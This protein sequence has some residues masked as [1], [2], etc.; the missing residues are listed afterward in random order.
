MGPGTGSSQIQ[1]PTE[2]PPRRSSTIH[3]RTPS[4]PQEQQATIRAVPPS[5]PESNW[6]SSGLKTYSKMSRPANAG[7][8][9]TFDSEVD[10][11]IHANDSSWS[12][13]KEKIVL[14]PYEYLEGNPGKDIRKQLIAAF[15]EWLQVPPE[16][17]A[18]IHKV[19][20]MLHTSSLL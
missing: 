20:G 5:L 11:A 2:I 12:F 16:S 17:L 15:N 4:A 10:V 1:P 14:G 3:T 13:E 7:P 19:V 8:I 18:I 6:I 9:P